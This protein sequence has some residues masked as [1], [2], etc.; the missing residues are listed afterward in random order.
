MPAEHL[1]D[2]AR[3]VVVEQHRVGSASVPD[4]TVGPA[5]MGHHDRTWAKLRGH[6]E[7]DHPRFGNGISQEC[8]IHRRLDRER[9]STRHEWRRSRGKAG[10]GSHGAP[11][12]RGYRRC[13]IH[14]LL[15]S[16]E[17]RAEETLVRLCRQS[18]VALLDPPRCLGLTQHGRPGPSLH[19]HVDACR[20]ALPVIGA[21]R[22]PE[23]CRRR[24]LHTGR[25]ISTNAGRH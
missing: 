11:H 19:D 13:C 23:L 24:V 18:H 8:H 15:A 5:C 7:W 17:Q 16:Q 2:D 10:R 20:P 1:P 9:Q 22:Q 12:C 25:R 4:H 14:S 6:L 3:P 21:A